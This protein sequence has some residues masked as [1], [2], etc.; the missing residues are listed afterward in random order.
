MT[1]HLLIIK[2]N[3]THLAVTCS[4]VDTAIRKAERFMNDAIHFPPRHKVTPARVFISDADNSRG[5][6][7]F[8]VAFSKKWRVR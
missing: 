2:S 5:L 3:G 8:T 7:E 6:R 1:I 4:A